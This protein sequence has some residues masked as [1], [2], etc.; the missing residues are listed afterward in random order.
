MGLLVGFP[1][2]AYPEFNQPDSFEFLEKHLRN[3]QVL[4]QIML[5]G[6]LIILL[7]DLSVLFTCRGSL[8]K[9][10]LS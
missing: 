8:A 2:S 5:N 10:N 3:H 4:Y 7:L 6:I 9:I 1:E